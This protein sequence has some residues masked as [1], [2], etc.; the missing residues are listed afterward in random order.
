MELTKYAKAIKNE[1]CMEL[2]KQGSS[3]EEFEKTL[4]SIN[5]GEGVHK[6]AQETFEI[7]KQSAPRQD[8]DGGSFM[9]GRS[10]G[11]FGGALGG[12]LG[13]LGGGPMGGVAGAAVGGSAG[14]L[15]G[16]IPEAMEIGLKGSLGG[17]A[18]A[19][20]G[21]DEMDKSV[22]AMNKALERER[23]KLHLVHRITQNLRKEHGLI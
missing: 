8:Q 9:P 17:G 2:A 12:T 23:D 10:L 13:F 15:L 7:I 19:G 18:L 5:T 21:L 14:N 11:T 6:F 4:E 1:L 20:L 3:L 16:T 22:E